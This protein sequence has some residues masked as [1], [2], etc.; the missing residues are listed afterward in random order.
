MWNLRNKS[1]EH[2]EREGNIIIEREGNN[3]RLNYREETEGCWRGRCV[4]GWFNWVVG[5][6]EGSW[7]MSTGFY[8]QLMSH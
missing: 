8:T 4:G 3:K 6:K 1:D 7:L 5:I 2:K